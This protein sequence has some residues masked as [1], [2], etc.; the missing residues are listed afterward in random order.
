MPRLDEALRS[1]AARLDLP[2]PD[3]A[4]ILEEIAADLEELRAEL[5]RRG[6]PEAEAEARAVE[7]LAPSDVAVRALVDVHEPLYR[8]LTRRFSPSVMRRTE[9]MGIL[10]VTV[11]ALAAAVIPM[12]R[13]G[14]PRDPSPFLI[15]IFGLLA[16]VLALMGR[17]AIQLW[18][19]GD[20]A[21]GRLRSGLAALLISSG[22]AV[23]CAAAGF[24]FELY[25]FAM[26]IEA[27]PDRMGPAL[28]RWILDASV[29]VGAGLVT[30]LVGG[31]CWFV[32]LQKVEAVERAY[33]RE[34]AVTGG[35]R[36]PSP[37]FDHPLSPK[38][39][40]P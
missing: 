10:V 18:V 27:N 34:A 12:A 31:L 7:L 23:G 22:L 40:L 30:A 32:L 19:E 39:A 29:L 20:H 13:G 8:A 17:K 28:T 36:P 25:R 11:A 15:P 16:G 5:V 26:R 33:R 14:L 38:G 2:Q 37:A 6:V 24:A 1:A 4:R 3:R 35:G 21:L 9:R